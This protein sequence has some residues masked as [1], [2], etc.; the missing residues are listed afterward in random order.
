MGGLYALLS[1]GFTLTYKVAGVL[2]FA[3]GA[4]YVFCAYCIYS[5]LSIFDLG[6]SIMLSLIFTVL[7]SILL[8]KILIYP[9]GDKKFHIAIITLSLAIISQEVAGL[10]SWRPYVPGYVPGYTTL[11]GVRVVNEIFLQIIGTAV[12]LVLFGLF[13][14][15]TRSGKS[16][17]AIAQNID[18][19]RLVGIN[20]QKSFLIA[21]GI[22]AF[23]TGLTA[24]LYSPTFRYYTFGLD[25]I[26]ILIPGIV[27]GGLSSFK[28][29][30]FGSYI[31]AFIEAI[32]GYTL[33]GGYLVRTVI[34]VV[35]FIV[36]MIKPS[37]L[38]GKNFTNEERIE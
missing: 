12:L 25:I 32:V 11:F 21:M 19:A 3:Q 10:T 4:I 34:F 9:L 35:M 31:V 36:I 38:F 22:S 17:K 14:N 8:Y 30:L 5:L 15:R 27:I 2:N 37:G 33:G 1:L 20:K 29:A 13:I 26:F 18:L 28:G 24:V 6:I 23:L 16:M 7:A